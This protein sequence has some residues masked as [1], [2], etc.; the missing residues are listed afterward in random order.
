MAQTIKRNSSPT[1]QRSRRMSCRRSLSPDSAK[2]CLLPLPIDLPFHILLLRFIHVFIFFN[3]GFLSIF[4]T[5]ISRLSTTPQ[6]SPRYAT[7]FFA[8]FSS[9][10]FLY[11]VLQH[12][13]SHMTMRK[14]TPDKTH[15]FQWHKGCAWAPAFPGAHASGRTEQHVDA[16]QSCTI[17]VRFDNEL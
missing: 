10:Q 9:S 5:S 3:R 16:K 4:F 17:A 15:N 6:F 14:T 11:Q 7:S 12:L 1:L 8:F 13:P 2:V